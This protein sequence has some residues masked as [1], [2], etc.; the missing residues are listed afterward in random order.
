MHLP[1]K[2]SANCTLYRL[3]AGAARRVCVYTHKCVYVYIHLRMC[4][5]GVY[6]QCRGGQLVVEGKVRMCLFKLSITLYIVEV[7]S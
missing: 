7:T 3:I 4:R 2:S 6:V 5:C 1:L